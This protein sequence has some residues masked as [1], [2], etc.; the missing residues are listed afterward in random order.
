M[1]SRKLMRAMST[2]GRRQLR[3]ERIKSRFRRWRRNSKAGN[4]LPFFPA[5][6]GGAVTY[7][8]T[9]GIGAFSV[10]MYDAVAAEGSE[11]PD[12]GVTPIHLLTFAM[13]FLSSDPSD[14]LIQEGGSYDLGFGSPLSAGLEEYDDSS[15]FT[16][17]S[18]YLP[19]RGTLKVLEY[20]PI[21]G[22]G[23]IKLEIRDAEFQQYSPIFEPTGEYLN[24][25]HLELDLPMAAV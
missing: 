15:S 1:S 21:A 19:I 20:P 9:S 11:Y 13:D 8:V 16:L 2:K 4:D 25:P 18:F 7:G 5:G 17:L 14:P 6:E 23:N 22:G 3:I 12:P 10:W 24:I